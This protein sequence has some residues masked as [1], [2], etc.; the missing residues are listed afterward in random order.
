M[1]AP[2]GH[3]DWVLT[4]L[5]L[6]PAQTPVVTDREQARRSPELSVLSALAHGATHPQRRKVLD[7]FTGAL[8]AV[9]RDRATVYHDVVSATLPQAARRYLERLMSTGTYQFQSEFALRHIKQGKVE[10]EAKALLT[11]LTTRGV[12]V[13]DDARDRITGCTDLDQL[14]DWLRRAATADSID[15]LFTE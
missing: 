11:F 6:G 4:P 12:D 9:D 10:G 3:P 2:C 5:V 15:D 13:P 1:L 7:A 14:D 8:H